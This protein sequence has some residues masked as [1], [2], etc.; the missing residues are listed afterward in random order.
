M[1]RNSASDTDTPALPEI[2]RSPQLAAILTPIIWEM[3][4]EARTRFEAQHLG[5]Y[6]AEPLAAIRAMVNDIRRAHGLPSIEPQIE[7]PTGMDN[8]QAPAEPAEATS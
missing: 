5:R 6:M 4:T 8:G 3:T 1:V 7:R 2:L